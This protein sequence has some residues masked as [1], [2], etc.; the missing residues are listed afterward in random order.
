[1]IAR[2]LDV[3]E[4]TIKAHVANIKDKTN[5]NTLFQLGCYFVAQ[6]QNIFSLKGGE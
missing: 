1:M 3:K 5:L 6:G 4:R 2:I